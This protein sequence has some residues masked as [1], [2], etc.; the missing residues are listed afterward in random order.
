[1]SGLSKEQLLSLYRTMLLIRRTEEQLIKF[2][3]AGEITGGVHTYIG[4]EAVASGV[5]AHL[6][7]EDCVFGTHRGHG[8]ALAKGVTPAS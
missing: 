7:P 5:C 2:Y 8:H 4:E 6:R 1:M 3:A